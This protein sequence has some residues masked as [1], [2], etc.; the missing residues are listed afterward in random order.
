[1]VDFDKGYLPF[2]FNWVDLTSALTDEDFGRVV[3][4][5]V[6]NFRDG[7]D[8]ENLPMHLHMAYVFMLDGAKRAV[9]HQRST[10]SKRRENANN[11]W[12]KPERKPEHLDFDVDAAVQRALDR[13][14]SQ[15]NQDDGL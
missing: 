7:T 15:I 3:R 6:E 12:N 10:S 1:M 8:P 5:L 13:S 9:E 14:Y 2:F 11:R 4:A